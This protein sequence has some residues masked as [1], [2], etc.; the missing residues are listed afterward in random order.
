VRAQ[1]GAAAP[2]AG[3]DAPGLVGQE[4]TRL[5]ASGVDSEDVPHEPTLLTIV[6]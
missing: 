4:R 2:R 1:V 5:R 6:D 3:D